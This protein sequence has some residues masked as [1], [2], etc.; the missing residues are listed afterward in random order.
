MKNYSLRRR[1]IIWI[2]IPV[3]LASVLSL[4]VGFMFSWHEIEEVYDAQMVHSAKLLLQIAQYEIVEQK[5]EIINLGKENEI[6]KQE[7]ENKT[8]FRIWH[9]DVILTRS[10]NTD[11][12]INVEATPGF[13]DLQVSGKDWRFFV[14]IDE[15]NGI[16]VEIAQRYSIR[17]ELIVQLMSSLIAPGV[18]FI[19][20]I[21]LIVWVGV[22]KALK[23]V[24]KLS[25]DVDQRNSD[26]LSHIKTEA[27]PQ[28]IAPIIFALNRLFERIKESFKREREF[29]DHAAHELR[30]PLAAMK[31]QTQVLI[32]KAKDMPD[33][34]EGLKNLNATINRSTHLIEQLLSLARL[35]NDDLPKVKMNLSD[36]IK[37][38]LPEI[39]RQVNLKQIILETDI[40]DD[41]TILGHADSVGILLGNLADNAIKYTLEGGHISIKLSHTGLWEIADTGPGLNDADKARVFGRFVRADKTGQS[42]SGLGLSIASWIAKAHGV[43]IALHDNT[44]EGLKASIKWD[45][46]T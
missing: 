3:L 34:A 5:N 11:P 15:I 8:A 44:P 14:F 4:S 2:S 41:V 21:L 29:T 22:Q 13:S 33:C 7:Y 25:T 17:Y 40:A 45:V 31:T 9:N 43:D 28:E 37:N 24:V 6:L 23:P 36:C 35:Q 42:G 30:T 12:F 39:K 20:L 16:K 32:K 26:D 19:P 18:I 1:L 38:M 27:L 46:A 10:W